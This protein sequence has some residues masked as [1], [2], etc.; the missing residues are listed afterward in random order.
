MSWLWHVLRALRP[1]AGWWR[2]MSLRGRITLVATAILTVAVIAGAVLTV[3][4]LRLSLTRALDSSAIRTGNDVAQ[5]VNQNHIP[6][7]VLAD[8]GG[9]VQ[10]Q[11]VDADNRVIGASPGADAAVSLLTDQ[12]LASVR[13]GH[14]LDIAA[15]AAG[16][17]EP[18]RVV[19]VLAGAD[20][21]VVATD[22]ARINDAVRIVRDAAIIG[23]PL[24]IIAM[25][26]LSYWVAGQ[27]LRTVATVRHGAEE[28]TAAGL[29]HMRL[30]VPNAQDEINRLVVTL[31]AMLDRIE[32]STS[33]QR[34]FVGDAA[35][36]LR[37]PIA[38]LRVQLEVAARMG[39]AVDWN[40]IIDDVLIDVDR[41]D[42]LVTDLLTLARN[43]ESGGV[44]RRREPVELATLVE[45]ITADY[46]HARVPVH[47]DADATAPVEG[48]VDALRR[49]IVNLVDNAV[50]YATGEVTVHVGRTAGE[51]NVVELTVADDGPGIPAAERE[52]VFDRF[53]RTEAS[54]SR[55]LG[56][57]GLGLPIVRELLRSHGGTVRLED[58]RPGLRAVVHIPARVAG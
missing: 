9:I 10:V 20:T 42:H 16:A 46:E 34:T 40:E 25:A 19:G 57:T 6:N 48:D 22:A 13:R 55:E 1:R 11:V 35:H 30:P 41:L 23:C 29:S 12:Q 27:T 21:V 58:N 24:A 45:D 36:E 18:L 2:E 43:D 3:I 4:V 17:D 51:E 31:N 37:S 5:L 14:R 39:P 56:G 53:Y 54:R 38:S 28:I 50:R 32:Q 26:L 49:V 44:L 15:R 47:F 7:P 8:N 33:R 52:R